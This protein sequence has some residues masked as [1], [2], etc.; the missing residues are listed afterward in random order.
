M[1]F[2]L[3]LFILVEDGGFYVPEAKTNIAWRTRD[4]VFVGTKF[5][6]HDNIFDSSY[7]L[8]LCLSILEP[9]II[10]KLAWVI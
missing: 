2:H 1:T 7:Q 4:S 3:K 5:E 9:F 8:L 10:P 6:Q